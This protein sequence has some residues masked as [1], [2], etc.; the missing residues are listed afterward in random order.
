MFQL[1]LGFLL[2]IFGKFLK[3][4]K[5]QGFAKSKRFWWMFVLI[6]IL[7]MVAQIFIMNQKGEL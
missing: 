6:G 3:L 7:S 1:L 4:T 5:E 2:F